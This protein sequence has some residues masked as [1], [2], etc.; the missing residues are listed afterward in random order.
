M[1]PRLDTLIDSATSYL[2]DPDAAAAAVRRARLSALGRYGLK[3]FLDDWER[4]LEEVR[5]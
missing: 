3:R 4:L 5:R 1:S 2:N